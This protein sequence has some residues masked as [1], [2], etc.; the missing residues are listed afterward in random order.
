MSDQPN[1]QTPPH[2]APFERAA[3]IYCGR[4]GI[5]ADQPMPVPHPVIIG[6]VMHVPLWLGVAEQLLDL[7]KLLS[8][9]KAAQKEEQPLVIVQ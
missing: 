2:L 7:S 3:R 5:D 1:D 8:C 6:S 9:M 4:E